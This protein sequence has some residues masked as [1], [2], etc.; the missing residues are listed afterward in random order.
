MAPGNEKLAAALETLRALQ[1]DGSRVFESEQFTRTVR[2]R[3]LQGG[4]LTEAMG[5]WLT[6][7]SPQAHPGDTTP[8]FSCFWEFLSK[9]CQKRFGSEWCLSPEHSLLVHAEATAIPVQVVVQSPKANNNR[10]VLPFGTSIF[11]LKTSELVPDHDV[12]V[13]NGL[14]MYRAAAALV[15]ATPTFFENSPVEAQIVLGSILEP[16]ELLSRLLGGGHAVVAGRLASAFRQLGRGSIADEI[17]TAMKA[18]GH[19]VREVSPISDGLSLASSSRT[20]IEGRLRAL[21]A[22]MRGTVEELFPSAPGIPANSTD[23]LRDLDAIYE[24]DAY[25]SLSIEGYQVSEALI[26][27]VADGEWDPS[28]EVDQEHLSALAAHGYWLAFKQVRAV[29]QAVLSGADA[30]ALVR[31]QHRDWYRQLFTPHVAAGLFNQGA[32]AGYR[33]QPIYLRGSRHV[34]PRWELMGTAMNVLFDLVAEEPQPG[35]RAVLAHWL[36]G[37]VHPFPDGNGRV[38]RFVMNAMLAG[39]GYRWTVIRVEQRA[40]YLAALETASVQNDIAPFARFI[41]EQLSASTPASREPNA[42]RKRKPSAS[43]KTKSKTSR[44]KPRNRSKTRASN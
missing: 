34:P 8:W 12:E 7:T 26:Q 18:A 20:P 27:R 6:S 25:H 16:S 39:G 17:V 33:N 5:G 32:L 13:R 30:A 42:S 28:H 31:A 43:R 3:L 23:Y 35:V 19:Q 21:W 15:R 22:T 2:E 38:A 14:R 11:A 37:Y 29:V 10:V 4:F 24:L 1:V 40:D 44:N 9:Y 36:I 41:A